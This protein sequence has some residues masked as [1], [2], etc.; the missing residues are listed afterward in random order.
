MLYIT[1][2]NRITQKFYKLKNIKKELKNK[3]L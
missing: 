2:F 1:Y 3:K